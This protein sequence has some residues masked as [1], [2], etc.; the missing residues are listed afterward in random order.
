VQAFT[1]K[2]IVLS[3]SVWRR[4]CVECD[5]QAA[6]QLGWDVID[7]RAMTALLYDALIGVNKTQLEVEELQPFLMSYGWAGEYTRTTNR[8]PSKV[9]SA[10]PSTVCPLFLCPS[11]FKAVYWCMH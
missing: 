4:P 11:A 8:F 3:A 7:R 5:R 1:F 9:A 6:L 2:L 10:V